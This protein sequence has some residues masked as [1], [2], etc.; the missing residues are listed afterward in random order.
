M[1]R[2]N[3]QPS[4]VV[5]TSLQVSSQSNMGKALDRAP[6]KV[7]GPHC[8]DAEDLWS[9]Y[10]S[11]GGTITSVNKPE[12]AVRNRVSLRS[13]SWKARYDR[14][15]YFTSSVIFRLIYDLVYNLLRVSAVSPSCER[16]QTHQSPSHDYMPTICPDG[17]Q[18]GMGDPTACMFHRVPPFG[19]KN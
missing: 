18:V 14:I 2:G 10:P 6:W 12:D 9:Y 5:D 3:R 7:A 8:R 19:N 16:R 1:K 15:R 11:A 17:N 13:G 4:T